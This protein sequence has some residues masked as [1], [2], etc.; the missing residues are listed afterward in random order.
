MNNLQ[1]ELTE[2]CKRFVVAQWGRGGLKF[3]KERPVTWVRYEANPQLKLLRRKAKS[4]PLIVVKGEGNRIHLVLS[5]ELK[6][7]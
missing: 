3:V 5:T 4:V 1:V 7:G 6:R 2:K